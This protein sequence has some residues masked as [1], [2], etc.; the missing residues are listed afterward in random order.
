MIKWS[1]HGC[2]CHKHQWEELQ[3]KW[4]KY[5][6]DKLSDIIR[7]WLFIFYFL[8]GKK[9]CHSVHQINFKTH[10]LFTIDSHVVQADC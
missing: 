1:D 10:I 9:D 3:D 5:E 7:Y 8:D 2:Q 6:A 4:N